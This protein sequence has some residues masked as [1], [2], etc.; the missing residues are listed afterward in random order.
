MRKWNERWFWGVVI[1]GFLPTVIRYIYMQYANLGLE[2]GT[3][4]F[5][6]GVL[7]GL[8]VLYWAVTR[9]GFGEILKWPF[10]WLGRF[11]GWLIFGHRD[12]GARWMNALEVWSFLKRSNRGW[13]VDGKSRRLSAKVSYMGA[14]TVAPPG[15][16]KSTG[17]VLPNLFTLA[18]QKCSIVVTDPSGELYEQSSGYLQRKG[19]NIQ[20]LNLQDLSASHSYNPLATAQNFTEIAQLA[21]LLIRSSPATSTKGDDA[22][23]TAGAETL[24]RVIIQVLHNQGDAQ[25]MHLGEVKHW[26]SQFD[27]FRSDGK[28]SVFD[29]FVLENTL[30]DPATWSA[31]KSLLS[32]PEKTVASFLSTANVALMA[33]GDPALAN[34]LRRNQIDFGAL[35][36]RKT[37]LYLMVR[38]QDM[39]HFGFVL[40]AFY[41]QLFN[42]LLHDLNARDLPVFALLDEWGQCYA[43]DFDKTVTVC[44]KYRVALFVFLQSLQQLESR[45]STAQAR[46]ILDGL[47]TEIFL[48]G[49]GLNEAERLT[50]R[51]GK[52]RP[53]AAG[54]RLRSLDANLQNPDE[55][56]TM[57]DD[58]A[59]LVHGNKRPFKYRIKPFFKHW[60]FRQFAK[61]PAPPL[62]ATPTNMEDEYEST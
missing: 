34:L 50:R 27:H 28:P 37:V 4:G 56:I 18:S 20:V 9:L 8:A 13:L 6:I 48:A 59:L 55:L 11:L 45:Y 1:I 21:N 57:K 30:E 29:T 32:G 53:E 60:R 58:E 41:A 43:P 15:A 14:L 42:A 3:A 10:I 33:L 62:P 26:L 46:T 2:L 7:A 49:M 44:R 19:F 31:Y 35:R 36:K 16:G 17:L 38:Q 40:S 5:W 22:Y 52:K 12:V 54:G 39:T 61:L 25:K 47:R 23:W 24:L 51:L